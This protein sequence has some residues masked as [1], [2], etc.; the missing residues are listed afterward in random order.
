[1]INLLFPVKFIS[2]HLSILIL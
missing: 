2:Y 1:V